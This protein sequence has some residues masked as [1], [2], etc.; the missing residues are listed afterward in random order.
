VARPFGMTNFIASN[1]NT[2]PSFDKIVEDSD[3][4][5]VND[6]DEFAANLS[7]KENSADSDGDGYNDKME[8]DRR[9]AGFDPGDATKPESL[10]PVAS[11]KDD[12]G[13]GLNDCEEKV[14]GTDP[15]IVDSDRDRI[16]DGVEFL[17]G[18]DP[19]V[20]DDKFDVD[21]DGHLS[22]DEI[23]AHSSPKVGDPKVHADY[24]YIYDVKE[25]PE[26][27][28]KRRCYD[29]DVRRIRLLTTELKESSGSR[30]YNDILL[31]FGEGPADDPRDY[32]NFKAACVRAQYVEP[33]FKFPADGKVTLVEADFMDL[34][35]LEQARKDAL[36]DPACKKTPPDDTCTDPCRGAPMP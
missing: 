2:Q 30:G 36:T 18:M 35:K 17:W 25:Q 12:D 28:D 23:R 24:R 27:P 32:G 22:G 3:G 26:R 4:D 15:K 16:P 14:L 5:G 21:F 20:V 11:R 10:C 6:Q 34:H 8:Y 7:M 9:T 31:Y 13:D 29:F 33:D 1:L 19:L